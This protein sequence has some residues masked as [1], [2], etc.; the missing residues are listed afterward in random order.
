M[1]WAHMRWCLANFDVA[2]ARR[3]SC[4][5]CQV[6]LSLAANVHPASYLFSIHS[7]LHKIDPS[8]SQC[9]LHVTS[10]VVLRREGR[11]FFLQLLI[12]SICEVKFRWKYKKICAQV[13]QGLRCTCCYPIC[14][15]RSALIRWSTTPQKTVTNTVHCMQSMFEFLQVLSA[16]E[17]RIV[18]CTL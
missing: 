10:W 6:Y 8:R 7:W 15:P 3:F 5:N 1:W 2:W 11:Y 14:I 9:V 18:C 17:H 12:I 13:H 4:G 16:H